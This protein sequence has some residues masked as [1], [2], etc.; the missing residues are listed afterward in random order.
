MA[1]FKRS[2]KN[3]TDTTAETSATHQ[4]PQPAIQKK[5]EQP[6]SAKETEC[7]KMTLIASVQNITVKQYSN[8]NH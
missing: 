4:Q 3:N 7:K 6:K 5:N 1:I 8:A 2:K